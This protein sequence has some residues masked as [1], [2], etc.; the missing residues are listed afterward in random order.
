MMCFR[1]PEKMTL[2]RVSAPIQTLLR[3][4]ISHTFLIFKIVY[5]LNQIF[6]YLYILA[7]DEKGIIQPDVVFYRR[8]STAQSFAHWNDSERRAS[9]NSDVLEC[10]SIDS[11]ETNEDSS[12]RLSTPIKP[13]VPAY[14]LSEPLNVSKVRSPQILCRNQTADEFTLPPGY[15][16]TIL[17]TSNKN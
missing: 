4:G 7:H 11:N 6:I 15:V 12:V 9:D 16:T 3:I 13:L 2:I 14:Q 1:K 5:I 8:P 10:E 17:N